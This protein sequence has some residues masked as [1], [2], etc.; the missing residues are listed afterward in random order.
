MNRKSRHE[1]RRLAARAAAKQ[2]PLLPAPERA[3]LLEGIAIMLPDTK[4]RDLARHTAGL[5]RQ[6]E[7]H[8]SKLIQQLTGGAS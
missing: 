5:I 7:E 6:S 8:Q 4:T 2:L 3:N 1:L